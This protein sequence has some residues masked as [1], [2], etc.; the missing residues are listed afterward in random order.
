M[1]DAGLAVTALV[2]LALGFGVHR[3]RFLV[4]L[5]GAGTIVIGIDVSTRDLTSAGHDDRVLV[6]ITEAATL[7]GLM[8]V[9]AV[10]VVLR[11]WL[12]RHN[13]SSISRAGT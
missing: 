9:F 6:A 8:A 5:L 4:V 13:R 1:L 3:W 2:V 11:R 7:L 10:G 12:D